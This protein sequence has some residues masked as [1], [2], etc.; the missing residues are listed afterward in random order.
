MIKPLVLYYSGNIVTAKIKT[1]NLDACYV[2][3]K[4]DK[5]LSSI[6]GCRYSKLIVLDDLVAGKHIEYAST[7]VVE[8]G[9][10][11]WNKMHEEAQC[12]DVVCNFR[13][14]GSILLVC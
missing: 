7:R 9:S 11:L 8:E 3:T 2:N 12:D 14:D 4:F 1:N 13:S 5:D 10:E 6:Q